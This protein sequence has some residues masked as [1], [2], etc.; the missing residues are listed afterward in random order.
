MIDPVA[1]DQ[2]TAGGVL[3]DIGRLSVLVGSFRVLTN[4]GLAR[5]AANSFVRSYELLQL[6][7]R[8]GQNIQVTLASPTSIGGGVVLHTYYTNRYGIPS[9]IAAR[10]TAVLKQRIQEWS[11]TFTGGNRLANSPEVTVPT[12][13]GNVVAVEINADVVTQNAGEF[14]IENSLVSLFVNGE[15][16]MEEACAAIFAMYSGRPGLIF[17]IVIRPGSTFYVQANT[18]QTT[19]A[20]SVGITVRMYF[21]DDLSGE[22][23][24]A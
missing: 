20:S 18:F 7:Q 16:I 3:E 11:F 13:I 2:Y 4:V 1:T 10:N 17:P 19:A 24:Y 8:A 15:S 5:Y 6:R 9:V 21:D 23:H 22:I 12:G 14:P